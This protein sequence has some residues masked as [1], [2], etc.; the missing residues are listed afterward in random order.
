LQSIQHK[1]YIQEK[2][3]EI[4]PIMLANMNA[5]GETNNGTI[6]HTSIGNQQAITFLI[7]NDGRDICIVK[8]SIQRDHLIKERRIREK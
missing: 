8:D 3:V 1:G 2:C 4:I 6:T 7:G 5:M